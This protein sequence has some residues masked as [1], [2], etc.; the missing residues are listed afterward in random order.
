MPSANHRGSRIQGLIPTGA[1]ETKLQ[2]RRASNHAACERVEQNKPIL[3]W[4]NRRS[5]T[6]VIADLD[7]PGRQRSECRAPPRDVGTGNEDADARSD[8]ARPCPSEV[9][10]KYRKEQ[11]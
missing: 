9:R 8:I 4:R 2:Y 3:S 7:H 5:I 11:H 10:K 6:V 1:I